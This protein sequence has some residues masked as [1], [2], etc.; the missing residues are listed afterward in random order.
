MFEAIYENI[1]KT[2]FM[3]WPLF[4]SGFLG[5]YMIF[6][7]YVFLVKQDRLRKKFHHET[8]LL[9]LEHGE[10]KSIKDALKSNKGE[11]VYADYFL[12]IA[13]NLH[14]HSRHIYNESRAF[15][16]KN[17]SQAFRSISTIKV[18]AAA[19]PLMGL[20][21]TVNGMITTFEII[22]LYGNS[23]PVLMADGISKALLTTQAGLTVAFPLL[24]FY[25]LLN[26]RLK[27]LRRSMEDI[28]T[29]V[30]QYKK[31]HHEN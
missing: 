27:K 6:R 8:L 20:L 16:I 9:A 23:N 17:M 4:F 10:T 29:E 11:S 7:L 1:L 28:I 25:V 5:W 18:L 22:E 15:I 14:A 12:L 2:G 31:L 30:N 24:F 3:F 26:N 19:A 21:G 13:E